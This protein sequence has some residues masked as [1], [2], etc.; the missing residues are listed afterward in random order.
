MGDI[1]TV[2]ETANCANRHFFTLFSRTGKI[3][4]AKFR[5]AIFRTL[6]SVLDICC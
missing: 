5:I 1:P 4:L 3:E 6:V 2:P